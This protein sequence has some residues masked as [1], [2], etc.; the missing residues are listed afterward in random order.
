MKRKSFAGSVHAGFAICMAVFLSACSA[1]QTSDHRVTG[2]VT[3]RTPVELS[4]DVNTLIVRLLDVSRADAPAIE[5]ARTQQPVSP[6]PMVFV[7][8]YDIDDID[9]SKSYVVEA[10]I[11]SEQGDLLFRNE[12]SYRVLTNGAP[13]DVDIVV[14]PAKPVPSDSA[15]RGD[16]A[17]TNRDIAAI[18]SRVDDLR[19]I[20]G[21]YD[22]DDVSVSYK[23][24][25]TSD[26]VP[27]LVR[28]E[29][30]LGDYGASNVKFYYRNGNLLRF[31]ET[32]R[33]TGYSDGRQGQDN[34]GM[35]YH[36]VLDFAQGRFASGTKTIN[37]MASTPEDHE[38]SGALSQSKVAISRVDAKLRQ[39]K[40][41]AAGPQIF[42]CEDKARFSVTFDH[43]DER[44][45]V[46]FLGREPI[47]LNIARSGSGY[48][49][50]NEIY[51]LRGKG[52]NAIWQSPSGET[53]C[54]MSEEQTALLMAPGDFP[55]V[56]V[57]DLKNTS[58]AGWI[59][60][61]DDVYPAMTAC[62]A[63]SSGDLV[64]VLKA[65]PMEHGMVGVRTVNGNGT[66]YD[67][68]VPS[69]G[70]GTVHTEL[71]ETTTNILPGEGDVRF[72][73]AN[74]AYPQGEC[75]AHERVE[76]N[77]QFVGWLSRK[78]C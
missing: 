30:D 40:A 43:D 19:V 21:Q 27:V 74:S 29:R 72:T 18:E 61:F 9:P 77:G 45:I 38:I 13:H 22:T 14:S 41:P 47:V 31:E 66:R 53:H 15:R 63:K 76:K 5:I 36:L 32:A 73:P 60:D 56:T 54:A 25:V 42:V 34:A 44:A 78:T 12:Q 69:D 49:Y 67:C 2:S 33:R 20:T 26:D 3:H 75:F 57:S 48:A 39:A 51:A 59:G 10:R 55:L 28:E 8:P 52:K 71:V 58:N 68:L 16:G 6:P 11:L 35:R 24:Y 37:D 70:L 62:L 7:L 50:D 1:F 46:E 4:A 65:W 23:A 64:S 17:D